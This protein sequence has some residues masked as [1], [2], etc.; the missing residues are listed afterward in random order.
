MQ[1]DY[2]TSRH[3][4]EGGQRAGNFSPDHFLPGNSR[5]N[6]EQ[7]GIVETAVILLQDVS[8]RHH[9]SLLN[10]GFLLSYVVKQ[11]FFRYSTSFENIQ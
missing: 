6:E 5:R 1:E 11:Q 9:E 4:G 2:S 3:D 8:V 7:R 10:R